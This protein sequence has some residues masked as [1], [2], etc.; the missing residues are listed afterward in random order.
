M[1][2]LEDLRSGVVLWRLVAKVGGS[3]G[4]PKSVGADGLAAADGPKS[5]IARIRALGNIN[6]VLDRMR[7]LGITL[8]GVGGEDVFN[9]NRDLVLALLF[10]I[11]LYATKNDFRLD[12]ADEGPPDEAAWDETAEEAASPEPALTAAPAPAQPHGSVPVSA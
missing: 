11:I 6:E 9:V 7:S 4:E 12:D 2:D 5:A 1:V 3:F 8:V 10:A